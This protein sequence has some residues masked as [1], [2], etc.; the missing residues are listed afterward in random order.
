M[1][2]LVSPDASS[3]VTLQPWKQKFTDA[4][5]NSL[6]G[7]FF[8]GQ[9]SKGEY[10]PIEDQILIPFHK[11][12]AGGINVCAIELNRHIGTMLA[13]HNDREVFQVYAGFETKHFSVGDT[14]IFDKADCVILSIKRNKGYY[15]KTPALASKT[16]DYWGHDPEHRLRVT[17]ELESDDADHLLFMTSTQFDVNGDKER[18]TQASHTIVLRML[19]ADV[20]ETIS[21]S[22]DINKLELSYAMTVHKA[23]GSEWRR[24]YVCIHHSHAVSLSRELLYTA[25]TRAKEELHVICER[26]TFVKGVLNQVIKGDTLEAK[27]KFLDL[28]LRIAAQKVRTE[29]AE[30]TKGEGHGSG[31]AK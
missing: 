27:A 10:D 14:C 2:V 23:Q 22:G 7:S 11:E 1:E 12:G 18:V 21:S 25:V 20:E 13:R 24:V 16:L 26:D 17:A 15:G 30:R 9:Y 28:K 6:L 31:L 19:D 3:R 8:K 29:G 5:A 4:Q